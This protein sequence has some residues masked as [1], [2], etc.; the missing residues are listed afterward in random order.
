VAGAGV[1]VAAAAVAS[2]LWL[3][4]RDAVPALDV[5]ATRVAVAVFENRTGDASLDP[6]GIMA[7]DWIAQGLVQELQYFRSTYRYYRQ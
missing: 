3:R 7:S 1:V 2:F 5:E 6:L 4:A